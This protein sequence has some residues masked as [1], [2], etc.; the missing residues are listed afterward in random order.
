MNKRIFLFSVEY[1]KSDINGNP[2]SRI[3]NIVEIKPDEEEPISYLMADID[4]GFRS[5][6]QAVKE[7]LLK[8][9]II[10]EEEAKKVYRYR[11][12][13]SVIVIREI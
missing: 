3:K 1:K 12:D 10:T 6:E 7:E 2:R 8:K 13:K 5:N 4:I 9:G 11:G